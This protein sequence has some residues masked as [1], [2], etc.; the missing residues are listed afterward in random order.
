MDGTRDLRPIK[1][2]G[3]DFISLIKNAI[4]S[5]DFM[6]SIKEVIRETIVSVMQGFVQEIKDLKETNLNLVN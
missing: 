4:S 5:E 2:D 3:V 1:I 6:N